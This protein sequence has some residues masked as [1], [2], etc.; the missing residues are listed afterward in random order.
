MPI[1]ITNVIYNNKVKAYINNHGGL[2]L[3]WQ[4]ENSQYAG[5]DYPLG[6]HIIIIATSDIK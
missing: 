4:S 6:L 3:L 1:Y 5:T 2:E